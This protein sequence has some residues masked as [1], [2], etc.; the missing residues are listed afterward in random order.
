MLN[1]RSLVRQEKIIHILRTLERASIQDLA[2][3]LGVSTWTIRRELAPLEERQIVE[4]YHGGVRLINAT[5]G[6]R[7]DFAQ[8]QTLQLEAKQRIGRTT[9]RLIAADQS[10][11]LGG[12]TTTTE[13]ARYLKERKH[14]RIMTN[15]LNIALELSPNPDLEVTCTGG[16]AD[17]DYYSLLGSVAERTLHTHYFDVA[18]IGVSGISREAGLTVSSQANAVI[19]SMMIEH[20]RKCIVVADH[21]K[22]EQISFAQLTPLSSINLLVTDKMP[23]RPLNDELRDVGV[24]IIVA[25]EP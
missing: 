13:V 20:A 6:E 9:A 8:T 11:V 18:V 22:F 25:D 21:S 1:K 15:A 14:L 4:R 3:Q 17:G 5:I 12:G 24:T 16:R 19:L 2:A 23:P 7:A 10:I